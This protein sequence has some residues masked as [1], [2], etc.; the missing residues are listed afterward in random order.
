MPVSPLRYAGHR[1]E[2]IRA[3][4][5]DY[6]GPRVGDIERDGARDLRLI[7]ASPVSPALAAEC[8]R[9]W[10]DCETFYRLEWEPV[11]R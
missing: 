7:S 8:A 3:Y 4:R 6:I 5:F 2:E 9:V 1:V 11:E 10:P